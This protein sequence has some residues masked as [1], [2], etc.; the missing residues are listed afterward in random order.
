MPQNSKLLERL[1]Q[2][3]YS[4]KMEY[5][6]YVV[7]YKL[8]SSSTDERTGTKT[9]DVTPF[10][11]RRAVVLPNA[12]RRVDFKSSAL[13]ASN[14]EFSQGGYGDSGTRSFIVD[15]RDVPTLPQLT[16]DDWLVYDNRKFQVATVEE[17]DVA[18]WLITAKELVGE[19]PDNLLLQPKTTS[20][21]ALSDTASATKV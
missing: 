11:V 18:G 21:L 12:I 1:R 10:K 4:L 19:V 9:T 15:R 5:G 6:A 17:L 20:Q 8:V 13:I 16:A 3:L 7:I 2:L 14:R